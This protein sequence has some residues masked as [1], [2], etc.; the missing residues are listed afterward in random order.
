VAIVRAD[1]AGSAGQV[2]VR[3]IFYFDA[4]GKL[5]TFEASRV[6]GMPPSQ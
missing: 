3:V 1:K 5:N 2:E 4:N 6:K